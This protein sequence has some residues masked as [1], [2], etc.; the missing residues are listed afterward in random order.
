MELFNS[1]GT[2][3]TYEQKCEYIRN[4]RNKFLSMHIDT[5]NPI[6]WDMLSQ[7]QKSLWT[8]YRQNLLDIPQQSGFPDNVEWPVLPLF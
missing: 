3:F 1:D 4:R 5:F 7:E 8:N 6:R 2:L